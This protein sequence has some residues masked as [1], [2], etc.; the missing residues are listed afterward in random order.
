MLSA[1]VAT[2]A[3]IRIS[4]EIKCL[5]YAGFCAYKIMFLWE[6]YRVI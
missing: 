1:I 4:Q 6:S 2:P 5:P 3:T